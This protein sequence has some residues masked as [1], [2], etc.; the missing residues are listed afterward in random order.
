MVLRDSVAL[1]AAALVLLGSVGCA[2]YAE[3][4][5]SARQKV[6][7]GDLHAAIG[8]VN[9]MLGV[10]S[11]EEL[12]NGW[13][14]DESLAVLERGSLLQAVENF[15]LSSRDL[16]AGETQIELLDFK[17]DTAGQIGSYVTA[18]ARAT[19]RCHRRSDSR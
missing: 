4:I 11:E 10:G 19:T 1:S 2:T 9:G 3:R 13:G 7:K 6:Q 5:E 16:S 14:S 15:A 18:T 8:E 12:P 17:H